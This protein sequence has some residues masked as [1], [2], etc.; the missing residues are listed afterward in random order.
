MAV[1]DTERRKKEAGFNYRKY[2]AIK[3]FMNDWDLAI[4]SLV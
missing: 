4:S 2:L 3:A 1:A